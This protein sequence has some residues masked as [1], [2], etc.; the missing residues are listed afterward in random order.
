MRCLSCQ[1]TIVFDQ[2]SELMRVYVATDAAAGVGA[3]S[4]EGG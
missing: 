4:T 1:R 2:G 3:D